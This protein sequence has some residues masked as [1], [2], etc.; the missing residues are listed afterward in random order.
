MRHVI[1]SQEHG[2]LPELP[3]LKIDSPVLHV[4]IAYFTNSLKREKWHSTIYLRVLD[5]TWCAA[6]TAFRYPSWKIHLER[7]TAVPAR[8]PKSILEIAYDSIV[9]RDP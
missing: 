8:D 3:T 1:R 5:L 7:Q 6:L 9:N 4:P 2:S